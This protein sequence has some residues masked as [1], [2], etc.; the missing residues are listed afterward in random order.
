MMTS[1]AFVDGATPTV[2]IVAHG[3]RPD[4]AVEDRPGLSVV[5]P[6]YD[7]QEVLDEL[8]RRVTHSCAMVGT[9]YELVL[10]NDGSRDRTWAI[11]EQLAAV[12][13]HLVAINLSRNHGHQLALTAGLSLARGDRVLI[14]D[15]DLQDPP[16][17][18]PAMMRIMDGGVDVVYGRR[19]RRDGDGPAKRATA[20]LFYRLVACLTDVPIPCDTGDFRLVS[21]RALDV[22]L[23]LPERHRFVRGMISWIGF[24][25]EPF[26]YDRCPR[27]AG[28]TKY[29]IRKM[30]RFALDAIT[31]F[32]IKPLTLASWAGLVTGLC[33]CLLVAYSV[34]AWARGEAVVGWTS[35]MATIALLGSVQLIVLGII[36]EYLGRTYEQVKGRPL[37]VIERVIRAADERGDRGGAAGGVAPRETVRRAGVAPTGVP[38]GTPSTL[39]EDRATRGGC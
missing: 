10:V 35:L 24:R 4:P 30:V 14:L 22:L 6:C 36:G 17:L 21:R 7:E 37:F 19:R 25:Q 16:E 29:P 18:L 32:S 13:R 1:D 27:H 2:A 28:R 31:A 8:H 34:A 12:D 38:G 23:G 9:D 33:A 39:P 15:A 11:M 26:A 20:A 3:R 5:V